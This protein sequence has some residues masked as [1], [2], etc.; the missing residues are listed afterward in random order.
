LTG[1]IHPYGAGIVLSREGALLFKGI[2]FKCNTLS[3]QR[4]SSLQNRHEKKIDKLSIFFSWLGWRDS[5]PRMLGPELSTSHLPRTWAN[6]ITE[7]DAILHDL[8]RTSLLGSLAVS[9][10]VK[11]TRGDELRRAA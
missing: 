3:P 2:L 7:V 10:A 4:L 9:A 6:R 5:N 1:P 8:R 11:D